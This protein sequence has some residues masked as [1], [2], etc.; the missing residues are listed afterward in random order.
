VPDGTT[1]LVRCPECKTVFSPPAADEDDDG[2]ERDQAPRPTAKVSKTERHETGR[3]RP[4]PPSAPAKPRKPAPVEDEDEATDDE[5]AK[6][7][8]FDPLTEEEERRRR[9]RGR[10]D[11]P[12]DPEEKA[13]RRSEFK[14]GAAGATLIWVSLVGFMLSMLLIL[15]YFF[16]SA[17]SNDQA[18]GFITAAGVIGLFNWL[19]AAAGVGLCLSARPAPGHRTFGIAAAAAVVIH[20]FFVAALASDGKEFGITRTDAR[21]GNAKW[22]FVP[23]R[24]NSTMF[25]MTAISYPDNQEFSPQG[26]RMVLSAITGVLEM[27]RTVLIMLFLSCLARAAMDDDLAHRCTRVAGIVSVGPGLLALLVLVFVVGMVE[28]GNAGGNFARVTFATV[29]MGVYAIAIGVVFPAFMAARDVADAC[30][31]PYQSLIPKL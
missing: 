14:R 12:L 29:Q 21:D 10:K 25:Y 17:V 13:R 2:G 20:L 11:G 26:K 28:T 8:D 9:K 19:L 30:N 27:V 6:N 24:L 15:G 31:E 3:A 22:A 5:G 16:Q 7:R 4:K 23:T 1:A 18:P